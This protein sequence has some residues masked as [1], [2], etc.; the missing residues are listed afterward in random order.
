MLDRIE[1]RL[2]HT[3]G[4]LLYFYIDIYDNSLSR[5]WLAAF[6]DLLDKGLHLEKN[7]CF[8]GFP[9]CERNLDYLVGEINRT[10]AGINGSNIDYMIR[11]HFTVQNILEQ[12]EIKY[13]TESNKHFVANHEKFNQLHLYFEETQGVSGAMSEHYNKADAETRWYIRQLNLLCHET[14]CLI[15]SLGQKAKEWVR[16]SNVMCW[17]NAPR[18]ILDEEDYELFGI[19]TI[20]RHH[21]GVYVGVNKA[22]G[23]HH[24]E[25]FLDEGSDSRID[26]LTTTT[27]KPQTEAAGD[28]DIEWGQDVMGKPFMNEQLAD[29]RKWLVT[30][31]F[32]PA[33]P[34]LTIGHPKIGQV[35]LKYSFDTDDFQG[36][37]DKLSM[38]LDVYSIKT[39]KAYQKYDYTWRDSRALQVP[40]L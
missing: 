12:P 22:V 2:R 21:G 27:L 4:K 25:V 5:K 34:Y 35:D 8:F 38:H 40:L 29:F 18:F 20:A 19:D 31:G 17:L 36:V 30:N 15:L 1:V 26:E 11:D 13:G 3:N 39:S 37:L 14:E 28:F 10:I 16:P 9:D 24:W 32:D 6:N 7:Y 33:D 23:K